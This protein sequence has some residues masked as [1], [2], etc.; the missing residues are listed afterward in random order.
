MVQMDGRVDGWWMATMSHKG[1]NVSK[2]VVETCFGPRSRGESKVY[3]VS[4][5]FL[6]WYK[7]NNHAF[8]C[9]IIFRHYNATSHAA[10]NT[11]VSLAAMGIKGEK[12]VV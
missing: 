2:E 10:K 8:C 12:L 1:C 5:H 4:H 7:K 11:S 6:P 9:K 3:R